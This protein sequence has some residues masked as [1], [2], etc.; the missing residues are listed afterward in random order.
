MESTNVLL[1]KVSRG[2]DRYIFIY[3]DVAGKDRCASQRQRIALILNELYWSG[4]QIRTDDPLLPK[5]IS[6]LIEI[7]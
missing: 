6:S 3:I 7:C 4:G 1:S 2:Y 5:Q